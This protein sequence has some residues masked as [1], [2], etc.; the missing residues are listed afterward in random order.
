MLATVSPVASQS[1]ELRTRPSVLILIADDLGIGDVGCF[2]N[3]TLRTP[4]I[5]SICKGGAKLSHHLAQEAACTPSRAALFTGRY[6]IRTGIDS[7]I[8]LQGHSL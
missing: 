3:N 1:S 2:G 4:H 7:S 6:P 8:I 5:D